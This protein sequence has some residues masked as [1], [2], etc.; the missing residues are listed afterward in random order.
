MQKQLLHTSLV[1]L[2]SFWGINSS[3]SMSLAND[4]NYDYTQ[5]LNDSLPISFSKFPTNFQLYPRNVETNKGNAA[6]EGIAHSCSDYSSIRVKVYKDEVLENTFSQDLTYANEMA[7]FSFNIDIPA[8]RSNYKIEAYGVNGDTETWENAA[9]KVVAGDIYIINGQS[10]AQALAAA[11]PDDI[12]EFTRSHN[13]TN[14]NYINFTFPGLW[15]ARLAKNVATELNIPTAIF[16]QA[17]GAQQIPFFQR[18]PSDPYVGNYGAL[19]KRL[20]DAGVKD[21]VKAGIWFHGE[22]DGWQTST[23]DYKTSFLQLYNSWKNDYNIEMAYVF[24][25]R[26]MS[27]SHPYPYILEAH[28]QLGSEW[29]NI[30]IMSTSNAHHDGCHFTY[31]NGYQ[32]LG[33]RLYRLILRDLYGMQMDAVM[34]PDILQAYFSQPNEITLEI[35]YSDNLQLIGFPWA[36]F[37][38]EGSDISITNGIV[39]GDKITLNLSGSPIEEVGITYLT[40]PGDAPHWITNST[41]VGLLSF[42]NIPVS[43]TATTISLYNEKISIEKL[44]PNPAQQEIMLEISA[45]EAGDYTAYIYDALGIRCQQIQFDVTTGLNKIPVD[46]NQLPAGI[47]RLAIDDLV[48]PF[49]KQ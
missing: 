1:I 6:I 49:S 44:Y 19:Y 17:E 12:D 16:N 39:N 5:V 4:F 29:D 7:P 31:E 33:D 48:I 38:L 43:Q 37:S 30:G 24:Q 28:R 14:W 9:D 2:F 45:Q 41:G 26:S 47:Y 21:H 11:N 23:E 13:G 18:D 27:C 8:E 3:F 20:E 10:N 15:G 32:D 42:Y 36:D 25:I 34:A 35:R 22:A 40:H 46:L